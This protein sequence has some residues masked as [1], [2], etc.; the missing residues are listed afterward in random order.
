MMSLHAV[1]FS[2]V[3]ALLPQN[4][5]SSAQECRDWQACRTLALAAADRHEYEAFHDL[6]WRTLQLGPKND[7]GL[8]VM[9]ARA[10]SLSG[11]PAD[12]MVMLQR[13]VASG[14]TSDVAEAVKGDDF[15]RVRA[16]PGWAEL[17]AKLSG[18]SAP[19][20]A[21]TP[22]PE[23]AAPRTTKLASA[24]KPAPPAPAPAAPTP[25]PE[26][27]PSG[28]PKTARND[29]STELK[30]GASASKAES[31]AATPAPLTFAAS[32][33]A[34]VGLAYDAVSGRFLIGDQQERRLVV[35]GERSGR[36]AS[37]AGSDAGFNDVTAFEIDPHE[38]DLWVVSASSPPG[39]STV[40]K[41][42]L[43][44]GRV[45]TSIAI[46]TEQ[47]P[48]RFSDVAVTPQTI[49]VLD[50]EGRRVF[51]VAKKGKALELAARLGVP[52]VASLAPVSE[53][54]AY[55]A[56]DQGLLQVDLASRAITV[57]EPDA[58]TNL[59][60]VTWIRWHRGALVALQKASSGTYRLLRVRLDSTG[61]AVR[62]V[63]VLADD[64]SLAGP[65]TATISGGTL[66]YLGRGTADTIEMKKLILK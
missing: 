32:S 35:V 59:S 47:A 55:A 36:L 6:S 15:E 62:G 60:G 31:R 42:Q 25:A 63:D 21:P 38:G 48:A 1:L 24:P 20:P 9:L 44:S 57:V 49:L 37:L 29:P 46:P 33:L 50:T 22:T 7:P 16:L 27:S 45:L 14:K 26:R 58:K 17:E 23:P 39:V 61:R 66:Y 40:H 64:V 43:V 52:N 54:S 4:A 28:E 30:V 2:V 8:M 10:Q 13:V 12:A 53:T 3:V 19:P 51:R 34:A 65:T 11:R 56:Y 5:T 41:L 18:V